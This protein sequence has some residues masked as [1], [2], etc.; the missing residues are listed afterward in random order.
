MNQVIEL[1]K[2]VHGV[3][4]NILLHQE[5]SMQEV[6]QVSAQAFKTLCQKRE[7]KSV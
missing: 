2:V 3:H 6:A 1:E 7:K 5:K 4:E